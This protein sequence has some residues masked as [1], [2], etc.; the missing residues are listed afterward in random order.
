M[1]VVEQRE[2]VQQRSTAKEFAASLVLHAIVIAGLIGSGLIFE[3]KGEHWGDANQQ[4]GAVQATMVETIPLPPRVAPKQDNV[5]ASER[6]SETPPKPHDAAEPPPR[7]IDIPIPAKRPEKKEPPNKIADKPAYAAPK[8]VNP[9]KVNPDRIQ[10]G[11]T[12]G[13]RIAMQAI[14]NKVGTSAI[15]VTDQSFGARFGYYVRQMNQRIAQQWFTQTLDSN[16]QSRRVYMTFRINRDGSPSDV[17]IVQS[18]GDQSLDQSAARAL[19]RID[20]FGPLP[21]EYSGSYISVQYYFE[22]T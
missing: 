2:A 13:V 6:P 5:L 3:K 15:N 14:Q 18:S 1:P 7:A 9:P 20:S 19:Q 10:T 22:P 4:A 11:Q 21:D 17:R 12:G 16:A 8:I